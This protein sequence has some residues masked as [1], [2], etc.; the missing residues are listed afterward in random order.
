MENEGKAGL[1]GNVL[2]IIT[3]LISGLI[4]WGFAAGSSSIVWMLLI[5]NF[6]AGPACLFFYLLEVKRGV[7]KD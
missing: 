3:I 7:F 5:I 4:L 1:M 6:V 2:P